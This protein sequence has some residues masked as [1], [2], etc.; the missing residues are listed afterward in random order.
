[1]VEESAYTVYH[2]PKSVSARTIMVRS[3]SAKVQRIKAK[4]KED[5]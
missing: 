1:M 4:L 5:V 2:V 3:A